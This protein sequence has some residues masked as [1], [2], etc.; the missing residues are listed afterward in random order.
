MFLRSRQSSPSKRYLPVFPTK[1]AAAGATDGRTMTSS[2]RAETAEAGATARRSR[3]KLLSSLSDDPNVTFAE[4][5]PAVGRPLPP[6]FLH[7]GTVAG[8]VALDDAI[9]L[10][11]PHHRRASRV[12]KNYFGLPDPDVDRSDSREHAVL[13]SPYGAHRRVPGEVVS[14][15]TG[16][17][18]VHLTVDVPP[19]RCLDPIV[20]GVPKRSCLAA[21]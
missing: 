14:L 13:F 2:D 5:P 16:H 17:V 21:A 4:D 1:D 6:Q 10:Y 19:V 11:E 8:P 7:H 20:Q 12:L 18:E 9:V 15:Q 3:F